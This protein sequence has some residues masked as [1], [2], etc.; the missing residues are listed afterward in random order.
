MGVRR[1]GSLRR[2][3]EAASQRQAYINWQ[4]L[5]RLYRLIVSRSPVYTGTLRAGW[6]VSYGA[7]NYS[8]VSNRGNPQAPL[9]APAFNLPYDADRAWKMYI[10]NGVPYT[11]RIENGW[12]SQAPVGMVRIS[13]M[14]V[15]GTR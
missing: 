10:A 7:P 3:V 12:S 4:K 11:Q 15:Y 8:F 13:K 2:L 5:G 6:N 9:P 1:T 14:E